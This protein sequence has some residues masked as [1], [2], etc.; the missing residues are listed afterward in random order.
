MH[1]HL[2]ADSESQ[3]DLSRQIAEGMLRAIERNY[4]RLVATARKEWERKY[5]GSDPSDTCVTVRISTGES[6]DFSR[7]FQLNHIGRW[8]LS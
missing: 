4:G 1:G 6:S 5:A 3:G 7:K 2:Q 8:N